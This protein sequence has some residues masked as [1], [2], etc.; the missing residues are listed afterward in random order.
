MATI[1]QELCHILSIQHNA[2]TAYQPQTDRQSECSNQKLKQYTQIFTDFHQTNWHH[3]LPLAQFAFNS[4]PNTTTKKAPF[5]L[6][7]DHIPRIHQNFRITTSLSLNNRLALITQAR[8]DTAEALRKSQAIELPSSFV[9][10]SKGDLVWQ[11]GKNLN[12]THPSAKLAPRRFRP[13]L[14]TDTVS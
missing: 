12:T 8:K 2:S 6:I 9:P 11:E 10:Y 13:F 3:L 14:V 1:I 4:W 5:E 7:M